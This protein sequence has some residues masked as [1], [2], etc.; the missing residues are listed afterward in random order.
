[1]KTYAIAFGAAL[2]GLA[3]AGAARAAEPDSSSLAFQDW[4]VNC[5]NTAPKADAKPADKPAAATMCE[6]VQSFVDKSS[7]R[8]V[9]RIAIGRSAS[10]GEFKLV[11]QAPVGIWLPDGATIT[12]GDK[13]QSKANYLRCSQVA[14]FAEAEAKKDFIEAARTAE[15]IT[16]TISQGAGQPLTLNVSTKGFAAAETALEK[17]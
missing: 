15:K 7:Q 8:P 13:L 16:L 4:T 1:M 2:A 5:A 9:A 17:K 3:L 12:I 11:V 14:C 10:G 6:M